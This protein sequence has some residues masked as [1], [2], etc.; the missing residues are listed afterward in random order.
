MGW[1]EINLGKY[2]A[3]V[4]RNM[5]L[6]VSD[7][8]IKKDLLLSLILAEFQK[9]GL[10]K[11]LIFKGGTL[12]SRI[13]L[14]YHR[15]SEDLDFVHKDSNSLRILSRNAR[16]REVRKF[17]NYFV[18]E[19]KKVAEALGLNFDTDRSNKKYCKMLSGRTVYTFRV[20]YTKEQYIKVEINFIEKTINE[21]Q[22]VSISAITDFFDSKKLMNDLNFSFANF[23]VKSYSIKEIILEK[24]RAILT[25]GKLMERDLFDLFLIE[26][27]LNVNVKEVVDKIESSSLIKKELK[28]TISEKLRFLKENKFFNSEEKIASLAIIK[29][30]PDEFTS[31]KQ[32]IQP[33]LIEICEQFLQR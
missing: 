3:E 2:V 32:R 21:P 18:P 26:N 20:Y 7:E 5:N 23:V 11:D 1:K 9:L 31:F 14:K 19:L 17:L 27:S 24:Y 15:F 4:K 28:S 30:S 6:I 8:I 10:G 25:R 12:L 16:E 13:Y 33:I 29:Y 22:E